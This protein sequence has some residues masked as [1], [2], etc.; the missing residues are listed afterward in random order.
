MKLAYQGYDS[1][2]KVVKDTIDAPSASEATVALRGRG[3]FI[4]SISNAME[5]EGKSVKSGGRYSSR[6]GGGIKGLTLFTRQLQVML[7]TGT[8]IIQALSALK[9]Q[10]DNPAWRDTI[11]KLSDRVEEGVALSEAMKDHPQRFDA[12]YRNLVAAGETSGKLPLM[13][14]RL[15]QLARKQ[16]QTRNTI[17]GA[18]V[19]PSLLVVVAVG[20]LCLM[21]TV[22]LPRFGDLFVTLDLPLPPTTKFLMFL[23]G[24]LIG[25]WWAILLALIVFGF[26]A[27]TWLKTE[28]GKQAVF[29]SMLRLPMLGKVTRS[30]ATA[31]I[32]RLLGVLMDSHLPLL[33]VLDL[34]AAGTVNV[35][36]NKLLDDAREAVTRGEPISTAFA[37]S[38]LI[39]PSVSE[40]MRSGEASGKVAPSLL[41]MSD[42]LDEENEVLIKSLTGVLEPLIL[43]GLGVLVGFMA[44]SIFLPLFDLT[45]MSAGG[46][47]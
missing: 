28:H 8:P 2:G 9:R 20:V 14:D 29:T 37:D 10:T 3:L 33:D 36:Y 42:M 26:A 7:A 6:G 1:S 47:Q 23:S 17:V 35:H 5:G 39:T 32:A 12:I 13:L 38:D 22:V 15:A 27:Y 45:A 46:P 19:Y 21:L 11:Q 44:L 34:I 31:R 18:L 25:Y 24:V 43:L 4:T 16:L 30:F 40:A 41:M